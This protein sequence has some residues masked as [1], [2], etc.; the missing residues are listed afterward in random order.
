MPRAANLADLACVGKPQVKTRSTYLRLQRFFA[1]FA[2]DY[3]RFGQFLL[4]LV[5]SS[6]PHVVVCDRT[7]WHFGSGSVNVLMIRIAHEGI[8]FMR[9]LPFRFRGRCF[10][11]E[12]DPELP[13]TS[14]LQRWP[15]PTVSI[16]DREVLAGASVDVP[17]EVSGFTD[18]GAISL[19]VTYDPEVLQLAKGM[20]TKALISGVPRDN[21]LANV[22]EP[23]ELRIAWFDASGSSPIKI[24][25]GTLLKITFHRYAGGRSPVAFAEDSEVGDMKAK[26]MKAIF[27]DGQVVGGP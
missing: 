5:P 20:D 17:I 19:I 12:E 25:D 4:R 21:F 6:P 3:A 7:E 27:Q 14:T 26:S 23:G 10:R 22:A 24:A 13:S 2:F 16:G 18:V 11:I 15:K 9:A 1:D 8:T